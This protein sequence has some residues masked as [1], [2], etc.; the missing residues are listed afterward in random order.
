MAKK[1][2]VTLTESEGDELKESI[3]K[4]SE[5]SLPV[6]RAYILLAAYENG[7]NVGK[8]S[9]LPIHMGWECGRWRGQGG[10]S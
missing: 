2:R 10:D 1:Y 3:R 9:A 6:K 4:R 5:K 8:M 7:R